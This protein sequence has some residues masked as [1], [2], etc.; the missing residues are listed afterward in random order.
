MSDIKCERVTLLN[1]TTRNC[2]WPVGGDGAD[3]LFCGAPKLLGSYC[4]THAMRAI[5]R[6]TESERTAHRR[7]K[8]VAA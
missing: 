8:A 6:G 1:L 7:L 2:R 5:G 3:T 4:S